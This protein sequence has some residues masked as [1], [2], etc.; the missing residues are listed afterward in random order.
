MPALQQLGLSPD[1]IGV[2][3]LAFEV[4][5]M[6]ASTA[7]AVVIFWRKSDDGL[8]ISISLALVMI[9]ATILPSINALVT[10]QPAWHLLVVLLRAIGI[11][12]AFVLFFYLFPDGKFIP[13]WTGWLTLGWAAF[14]LSTVLF[15]ALNIPLSPFGVKSLAAVFVVLGLLIWVAIGSMAQIYRYARVSSPAQRQQTKWVVFSVTGSVLGV[16][17]VSLPV[18]FLPSLSQPGMSNL[19]YKLIALSVLLVPLSFAISILRHR[20]WDID[21][22]IRRTMIYSALTGALALAY[23]S[24]VVALQ[25]LFRA[26]TGQ[27]QNQFVTVL[28]TL[29]IA[30]L[31]APLRRRVQDV[32]DRRFYRKKYDA[33]KTLAAFA[34]TVRDETDL[35][36]LTASLI[37]VVQETMQPE[38][39][40]LWLRA[41][42]KRKEQHE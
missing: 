7:I 12:L 16:T 41:S 27:G 36:K 1:A 31:F 4:L 42:P 23:F 13:A 25:G 28:S 34:A 37:A 39:V 18:L 11:G 5:F 21:I 38:H 3:I 17:S 15:P 19:A 33:A 2:Y 29:A 35:D 26:L 40:S 10:I 9:G 6:L 8:G 32:I 22:I 14:I 20:L 30:A 24:S